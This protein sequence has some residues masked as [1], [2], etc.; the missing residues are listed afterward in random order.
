MAIIFCFIPII[1][2]IIII[3]IKAKIKATHTL[4][5]CLFGLIAVLPISFLQFF[6]PGFEHYFTSVVLYS[7]LK[8]FVL[9]GLIEEI[10]KMVLLL[11]LPHKN[12]SVKN[13]LLL[14]FIMGLSLACFESL[15]YFLEHLQTAA[16][17]GADLLYFQIF[18]RI[19]TTD[20]IHMVCTGLAGLFVFSVRNK[21]KKV[22]PLIWAVVLHGLY[23]FFAGFNSNFK[24]FSIAV[25]LLA[26][27]ECRIKYLDL[28]KLEE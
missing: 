14:S 10:L 4:L 21:V 2:A 3:S 25:L 28:A 20:I 6:I 16:S 23:D 26:I 12:Y 24:Y 5:A 7:L 1:V 18:L 17:R 11:P 8:S 13:F 15:V 9:Y 19:F 22:S 27:I